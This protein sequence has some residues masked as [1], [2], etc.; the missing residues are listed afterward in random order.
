[1]GQTWTHKTHHNPNLGE[2]TTFPLIVYFVLDD[3]TSTQMSFCRN[4]HLGL[5]T[6]QR[7]ANVRAKNEFGSHISCSRECKRM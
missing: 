5:M 7:F 1:M 4:P 6:K 2:A 3:G